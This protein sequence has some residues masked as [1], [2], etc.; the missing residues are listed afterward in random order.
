[1]PV[2]S[3][4]RGDVST[5]GRAA[6]VVAC[7]LLVVLGG[8]GAAVAELRPAEAAAVASSGASS[9]VSGPVP[10]GPAAG[11]PIPAAGAP[12]AVAPAAPVAAAPARAT[13]LA[14]SVPPAPVEAASVPL[15]VHDHGAPHLAAGQAGAGSAPAVP[16]TCEADGRAGNRLQVVYVRGSGRPDRSAEVRDRLRRVVEVANG[17]VTRSSDGR[18][19][20]RV[21]TDGA[22]AVD[23][24]RLTVPPEHL[25][26]FGHLAASARAAGLTRSDR[27]YLLFVDDNRGCGLAEQYHDDRPG[28]ENRNNDGNMLGAAWLPCWDG[29]LAAH[30][31]MHLLGG[32]QP[33]APRSTGAWGHCTDGHDVMCYPDGSGRRVSARCPSSWASLLDCGR[34]DYFSVAPAA[35]SYLSRAWNTANNSFLVGGGSAAPTVPSPPT[36][37]TSSRT[38][39]TV[40][41][42]WAAPEQA[43][44]GVSAYEVVDLEA[45]GQ[46]LLS[47]GPGQH[48]AAVRLE[49]WRTYRLAVRARNGV[50]TSGTSG[51][52]RHQVGRAPA[53]PGGL[54]GLPAPAG[55][56]LGV[57]LSWLPSQHAQEYLVH[58][59][60]RLVARTT[61]ITWTDPVP[62]P[63]GQ[64]VVH[65]VQAANAWGA[66]PAASTS[67]IGAGLPSVSLAP[68][69]APLTPGAPAVSSLWR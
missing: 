45:R 2:P 3:A 57:R 25:G 61:A 43:R 24:P 58:R 31:V 16:V 10:G 36:R 14:C 37:V 53:A 39:E 23:V 54:S 63:L 42:R 65:A 27:K 69:L 6:L 12:A 21:V 66:S 4:S 18:R 52:E 49:P 17:V 40:S 29:L 7:C 8:S 28:V 59:D 55:G 13:G 50:G 41:L 33:S 22:C 62:V 56:N 5:R 35:G 19:A 51:D 1:M 46:V 44:S 30:E 11:L 64:T 26:S 32:V 68:R 15:C 67:T 20:L 47:T 60:G 34:D 48:Q 38:G 9:P